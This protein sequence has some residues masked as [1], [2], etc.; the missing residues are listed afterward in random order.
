MDMSGHFLLTQYWMYLSDDVWKNDSLV[1]QGEAFA[2]HML[3]WQ[4]W[5]LIISFFTRETKEQQ[6]SQYIYRIEA[7]RELTE[8][9]YIVGCKVNP[10]F[11]G[12]QS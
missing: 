7:L 10:G 3:A 6:Y 12:P 11:P 8:S 4:S 9:L 1:W 5:Q 2:S